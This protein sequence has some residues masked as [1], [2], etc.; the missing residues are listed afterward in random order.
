MSRTD[1]TI[2]ETRQQGSS[3]RRH[4]LGMLRR[5]V[6]KVTDGAFWQTLGLLLL[7]GV[8]PE[9]VQAEVWPGIGFY[10]RPSPSVNAEAIVGFVGGAQNPAILATRDED[11]RKRVAKIDQNETMMFNTGA[12]V[13]VDKNNHV[14]I[15]LA[16]GT[17]KR[18][19]FN[20]DLN[21]LRSFVS[22]QFTAPGHTH[23]VAGAATTAVTPTTTPPTA[24][25]GT[26]VIRGQ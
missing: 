23:A 10:A 2:A 12:V 25:S 22:D 11:T 16:N 15:R 24:Y 14:H 19:A 9:T 6:I 21:D 20:D 3:D 7:D 18:L 26:D 4:L 1:D 5:M 17:T 8:T 13:L